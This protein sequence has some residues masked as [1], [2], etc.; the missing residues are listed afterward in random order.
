VKEWSLPIVPKTAVAPSTRLHLRFA[1]ATA[2]VIATAGAALLWYAARHA[3]DHAQHE[4]AAHALFVEE[5]LLRHELTKRDFSHQLAGADLRRIDELIRSRVLIDGALRVKI[6]GRDGTVVYS[7][8]HSLIGSETDDPAEI[9][10]VLAGE[11]V[12]DV[13]RLG[14]EG[15]SGKDTKALEVYVP[16]RTRDSAQ[17]AGV[18][19]LYQSY[20]PV[21][22]DV[23]SFVVPFGGLLLA[24]LVLLW[25]ALFPLV[26]HMARAV[27]RDR[28]AR[29]DAEA[30]LEETSEQL[31]QSQK[32]EAIGRLA[33]GV[34]HDFNNLLLAINGYS[35]FLVDSLLDER[36]QRFAREIRSAGE[37]AAA[38]T[39]QLLA[40]SRK[41]VLQPRVLN[42]NESVRGI[43]TILRRLIG[44]NVR[45]VL[46]LEPTLRPVE[47]DPSQID[48]VLLNLAVNARDAMDARGRLRIATRN[49]GETVLLEVSDTG[50]GMDEETKGRI[51][52]PFFTTKEIGQGTGLGLSTVYGIVSQSGGSIAVRTGLGRGATFSVRLPVTSRTPV[53]AL[54]VVPHVSNGGARILVVDD[55]EI[56][57]DLLVQILSEQG[58]DV[59]GAG[60]AREARALD[61]R[62]DVLVTDVVM[63]ETDGVSLARE[64]D[65]RHVL[66]ISG[67]DQGALVSSEAA[68]LQKPFG[69]EDLT[70]AMRSLLDEEPVDALTA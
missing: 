48:Q 2:V 56:V 46:D 61:G 11:V 14:A 58:Y 57:R 36:Q 6:Y 37:R 8:E 1:A 10:A 32:M 59:V 15:G 52:E 34:A 20:A 55:E 26:Q 67:Y 9:R 65:A 21:A 22:A 31:R 24:A 38:L 19:E 41:Q 70:R 42:L 40:F 27:E 3:T 7:N 29:H 44:E 60:S 18:F 28:R 13:T 54:P 23:R 17:P 35:D 69:R 4:T 51:F 50:G 68:F 66:F 45:I 64:I 63:P 16:L 53:E 33:G 30:A 5:T 43:D 39:H 47:A 49:D 12:H 62:W 25:A